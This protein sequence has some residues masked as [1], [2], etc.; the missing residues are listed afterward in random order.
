MILGHFELLLDPV[1]SD[2]A[3]VLTPDDFKRL[4]SESSRGR[5]GKRNTAIIWMSFGSA[6]RVTEIANLK[7]KDILERDGSLKDE[8]RLPD[9]YTKNG[10]QG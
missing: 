9:A 1:D 6:L 4:L 7:V 10:N 3:A 5:N 8:Y 2:K